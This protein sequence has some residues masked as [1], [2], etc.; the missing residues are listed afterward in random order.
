LDVSGNTK[1]NSKLGYLTNG[2]DYAEYFEN[3]GAIPQTSIVGINPVSGKVRVYQPGDEFIGI[4]S[5][6]K[7]GF[8]G[9]GNKD[10]E[11]N[12]AYTLVGLIGQLVVDESQVVIQGRSVKTQDGKKIGILLS[13]GKVF[14]GR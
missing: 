11:A 13:N 1:V 3:E 5:D 2:A 4:A 7:S 8:V 6:G 9:N 12:P 10:I 14:V